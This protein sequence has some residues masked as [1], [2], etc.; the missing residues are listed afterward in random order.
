MSEPQPISGKRMWLEFHVVRKSV[1]TGGHGYFS[2]VFGAVEIERFMNPGW[3][4]IFPVYDGNAP[5]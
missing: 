5:H 1:D 2:N 4:P 3:D